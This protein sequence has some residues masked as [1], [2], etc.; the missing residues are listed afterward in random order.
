MLIENALFGWWPISPES[1]ITQRSNNNVPIILMISH[2][3]Y[4]FDNRIFSDFSPSIDHQTPSLIS[5]K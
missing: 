3:L 5:K 2:Y 1:S 4:N